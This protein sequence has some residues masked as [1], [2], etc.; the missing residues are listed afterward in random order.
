LKL[1]VLW[2]VF[3]GV[4]N[5]SRG[6]ITSADEGMDALVAS[7]SIEHAKRTPTTYWKIEQEFIKEM[8]EANHQK[9]SRHL[10]RQAHLLTLEQARQLLRAAQ[11]EVDPLLGGTRTWKSSHWSFIFFNEEERKDH[12]YIYDLIIP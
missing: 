3:R 12:S 2:V 11:S 7:I 9:K 6:K 4:K 10:S 1:Y 5:E 8:R